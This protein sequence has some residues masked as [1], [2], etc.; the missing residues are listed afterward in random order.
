MEMSNNKTILVTGANGYIGRHV[1]NSLLNLGMKVIAVDLKHTD[2]DPRVEAIEADIFT[3][4]DDAYKSLNK[5]DICLH[6]AWRNGF[7]HN[8]DSHLVDLPLHY[9]FIRKLVDDGLRHVAVMGSMHEVGYWVGKIDE[10]TPTNPSTLYGIAKNSLR[11]SIEALAKN[12]NITFQWLRAFYIVGDDI[13]NKSIF[14]RIVQ[15]EHEKKTTFPVTIGNNKC[16]F[17]SIQELAK[18]ISLCVIQDEI[19]GMI[20]CCTGKPVTLRS[21]VEDFIATNHFN[22]KPEFGSFPDRPYDSSE[23]W[24]DSKKINAIVSNYE[25]GLL[26]K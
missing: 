8:S 26:R 13:R 25:D 6:L 16:D 23:L 20:N 12:K 10:H 19:V 4:K 21:V 2:I 15:F 5:P 22:I 7:N 14:S 3:L 9:N 18:Q 17:I 1:V 11:Q 24:G